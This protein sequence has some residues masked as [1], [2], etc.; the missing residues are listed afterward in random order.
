MSGIVTGPAG[1]LA[2]VTGGAGGIGRA[3]TAA[4]TRTGHRVLSVDREPAADPTAHAALVADV[5]VPAQVERLFAEVHQR[6][7]LPAVLVNNAGVYPARDFLDYDPT[8]YAEV[9]DVNLGATFFGTLAY[10]RALVAAGRPGT[11]VNV[12]SISGQS[13]SPDAAYGAS[14]GAVIALTHSLGRALAGHR[15]RVN[16]VAPGL[17][18]TPMADRIPADRR[19]DYR[20]RIPVGR[21]GTPAEI[22]A[23]VAWLADPASSYVTATVLDVNGGLH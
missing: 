6:Y 1:P 23:A 4:L 2:V 7:G 21:F 19:D 18:D 8:T 9:L 10:A 22:A 3:V 16:A 20:A 13:G 11:V 15:I 5:A 14:K 17:V 12:A